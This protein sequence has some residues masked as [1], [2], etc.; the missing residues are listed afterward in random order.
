MTEAMSDCGCR[1]INHPDF[2]EIDSSDCKY[3]EIAAEL[4]QEGM[5]NR[6]KLI[7]DGFCFDSDRDCEAAR[8]LIGVIDTVRW[9]RKL[10]RDRVAEKAA[11]LKRVKKFIRMEIP[12]KKK[13]KD[14]RQMEFKFD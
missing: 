12:G 7:R 5:S 4:D 8:Y 3:T 9:D 1:I 13:E 10:L 6:E 2:R 11:E 14:P